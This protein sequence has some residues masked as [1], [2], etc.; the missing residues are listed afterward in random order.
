MKKLIHTTCLLVLLLTLCPRPAEGF[1]GPS[2]AEFPLQEAPDAT[3][4]TVSV[5]PS[6]DRDKKISELQ[7]WFGRHYAPD[8]AYEA[9]GDFAIN[10][11][12]RLSPYHIIPQWDQAVC[13][14]N[15]A[16]RTTVWTVPVLAERQIRVGYRLKKDEK[17]QRMEKY[18]PVSHVLVILDKGKRKKEAFI[19]VLCQDLHD[20]D[21]Y[22]G[23]RALIDMNTGET[24]EVSYLEKGRLMYQYNMEGMRS[25]RDAQM[26]YP[27]DALNEVGGHNF[28]QSRYDGYLNVG[29]TRAASQSIKSYGRRYRSIH[30]VPGGDPY[31]F[32]YRVSSK[33]N[34]NFP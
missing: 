33:R 8:F 14:R 30:Y 10:S 3:P 6:E 15:G 26:L 9:T 1:A 25:L 34:P 18:H 13:E 12:N 7:E 29:L 17:K 4:G 5:R 11:D 21:G 28:T 23:M 31:L 32:Q 22:T 24:L 2:A 27:V 19:R 16:G 20:Q